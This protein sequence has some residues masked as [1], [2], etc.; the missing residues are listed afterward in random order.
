MS[1][2]DELSALRARVD[3][4]GERLNEIAGVLQV[5]TYAVNELVSRLSPERRAEILQA[6]AERHESA[7]QAAAAGEQTQAAIE[8]AMRAWKP[9]ADDMN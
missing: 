4:L 1:D 7:K 8:K 6:V 5:H 3:E 2:D 9:P